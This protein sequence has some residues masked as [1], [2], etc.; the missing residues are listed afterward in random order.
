MY[1]AIL[2][3]IPRAI[4]LGAGFDELVIASAYLDEM[5]LAM[6]VRCVNWLSDKRSVKDELV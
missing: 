6:F 2:P 3:L 1:A 4:V 5:L